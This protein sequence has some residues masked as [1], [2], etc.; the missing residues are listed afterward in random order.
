MSVRIASGVFAPDATWNSIVP[1]SPAST[2]DQNS[3][4]R[5]AAAASFA[6]TGPNGCAFAPLPVNRS[7]TPGTFAE[8]ASATRNAAAPGDTTSSFAARL[9]SPSAC[10]GNA[11]S[12]TAREP[13]GML[14]GNATARP[15]SVVAFP[16][17][18]AAAALRARS[19]ARS[20]AVGSGNA[21]RAAGAPCGSI[22][23]TGADFCVEGAR[24]AAGGTAVIA[25]SANAGHA[26]NAATANTTPRNAGGRA[27]VIASP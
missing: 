16:C 17:A 6:A 12:A 19:D 8:S 3:P 24:Y 22:I 2:G 13:S 5:A 14:R 21:T 11:A 27:L 23:V 26:A 1:T 4:K 7:V 9:P 10:H 25:A 20:A 15:F 18:P